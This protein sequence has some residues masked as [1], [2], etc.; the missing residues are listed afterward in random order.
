M[1]L[2]RLRAGPEGV[3]LRDFANQLGHAGRVIIKS[4]VKG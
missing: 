1:Q 2:D 4:V 3:S